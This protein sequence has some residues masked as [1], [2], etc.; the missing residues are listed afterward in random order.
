MEH[1]IESASRDQRHLLSIG[2]QTQF[3]HTV[4]GIAHQLDRPVGKPAADQ[5]DHLVSPQSHCLVSLAQLCTDFRGGC[6]HTQKGQG[7]ALL[8][9]GH[10]DDDCHHDPSQAR[11]AHRPLSARES[12]IAVMPSEARS[13]CPSAAPAFRQS[14]GPHRRLL[15]QRSR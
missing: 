15:A 7:P 12:A 10:G 11:A 14:P 1:R 2:M 13:C 5:A 8:R 3:Q 9:P 6:Q 4:R